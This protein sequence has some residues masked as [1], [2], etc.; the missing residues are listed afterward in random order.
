MDQIM[1]WIFGYDSFLRSAFLKKSG[2]IN[3]NGKL[4]R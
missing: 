2:I 1:R 3:K 4:L